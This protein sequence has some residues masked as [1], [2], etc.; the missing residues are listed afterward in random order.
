MLRRNGNGT[1]TRAAR[2]DRDR[3][4]AEHHRVAGRGDG[5]ANRGV[6]VRPGRALLA[7][8]HHDEQRVVDRDPQADQ[9]DEELDDED[10]VRHLREPEQAQERGE[11]RDRG[12]QQRHDREQRAEH[13]RQDDQRPRRTEDD[14]REDAAVT[15]GGRRLENRYPGHDDGNARDRGRCGRCLHGRQGGG[16]GIRPTDDLRVE[17]GH[18]RAGVGGRE[19][20]VAGGSRGGHPR[21]RGGARNRR[22]RVLERVGPVRGRRARRERDRQDQRI[23]VSAAA[24]VVDDLLVRLVRG[25]S[26]QP[27]LIG[28][29]VDRLRGRDAARDRH[30]DPEEHDQGAVTQHPPRPSLHAGDRVLRGRGTARSTRP[31]RSVAQRDPRSRD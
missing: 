11:D 25:L 12:D 30:S 14:L 6:V 10:H 27:E 8:A 3:D 22:D 16:V 17:N 13:Q 9:P 18:Q 28:Q 31:A 26:G 20:A 29:R 24:E 1:T 15:A 23:R 7:P 19:C 21:A 5:G 4:A 2:D